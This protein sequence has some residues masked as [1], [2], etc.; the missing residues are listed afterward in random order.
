MLLRAEKEKKAK[1][2]LALVDEERTKL[3]HEIR[4]IEN[5]VVR[6][7][8]NMATSQNSRIGHVETGCVQHMKHLPVSPTVDV[9]GLTQG[10]TPD[11][12]LTYISLKYSSYFGTISAKIKPT[13]SVKWFEDLCQQLSIQNNERLKLNIAM[14]S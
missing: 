2:K 14:K 6:Q 11:T 9:Q 12:N 1:G 4:G 7:S 8:Q 13:D 5:K 10:S 3:S